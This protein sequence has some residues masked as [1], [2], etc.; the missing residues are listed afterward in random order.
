VRGERGAA[1]V[2]AVLVLTVIGALVAAVF[3]AGLQEQ[4]MAASARSLQRAQG[5]AEAGVGE[6]MRQW[7]LAA[8]GL[9][10]YP[11]DSLALPAAP[12]PSATGTFAAVIYRVGVD[13]YLIAVDGRDRSGPARTRHGL[14]VR[15][16]ERCDS[17]VV[18]G[19]EMSYPKCHIGNDF[20]KTSGVVPLRSRAWI[21]LF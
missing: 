19:L 15:A 4:R 21:Q 9:G 18:A 20:P 13:L 17:T 2:L 10:L 14:L 11:G 6:L 3:F 8:S 5:A 12:A 16:G 7:P 1:L